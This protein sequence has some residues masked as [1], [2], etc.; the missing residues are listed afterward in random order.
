MGSY[1]QTNLIVEALEN[2]PT[3]IKGSYGTTTKWHPIL[4][5]QLKGKTS[6]TLVLGL[7]IKKAS[8]FCFFY[9]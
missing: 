4:V 9:Y 3:I 2:P 6:K 5:D 1:C 8:K 7:Q